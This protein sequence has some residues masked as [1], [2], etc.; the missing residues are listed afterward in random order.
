MMGGWDG[1]MWDDG[2]SGDIK[3]GEMGYLVDDSLVLHWSGVQSV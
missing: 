2:G 3:L 1:G